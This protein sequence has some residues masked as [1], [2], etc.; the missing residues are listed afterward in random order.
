MKAVITV[1]GKD[2][3]GI[4]AKVSTECTK[5]NA[6]IIDVSQ[7]VLKEYCAMI[8]LA[9]ISELTVPLGDFVDVMNSLAEENGLKIQTMHEDIF[10]TMHRI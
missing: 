8:M 7:S 3:K 5:Y 9:D 10:N 2:S 4:I 6:N 1:T